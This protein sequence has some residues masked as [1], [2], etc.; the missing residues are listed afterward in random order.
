MP[1]FMGRLV[2]PKACREATLGYF[3]QEQLTYQYIP[4]AA[5][6]TD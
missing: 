3:D 2:W 4:V 6:L 1:P 5:H